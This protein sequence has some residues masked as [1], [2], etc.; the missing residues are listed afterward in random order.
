M[1][2]DI[3]MWGRKGLRRMN[4]VSVIIPNYNYGRF[5]REAIDSALNQT[6]RPHE[7]IVVDDGSTDQSGEILESYGAQIITVRQQNQGVGAARNK[8]AEI[9][10]GEYLAFLDADDY[11][12]PRKL[13]KQLAKFAEDAEIG[14]VHCGYRNV[15]ANGIL[16]DASL[17]GSE[18]WVRAKLLMFEPAIAAPGGTTMLRRAVFWQV[19]GYDTNPDLHPSEDWDLSY[20]IACKWKYGFVAEPLL[21]Y[22]QHGKGGHTNIRRMERAMLIGFGKAFAADGEVKTIEVECYA[23]LNMVLAGS[24]F[25]AGQYVDFIRTA[26]KS[27]WN[28]PGN[29]AY[30][31]AFPFR[32]LRRR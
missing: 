27:I 29:I 5:L 15:D 11:W 4:R 25:R 24:Y 1:E 20:R 9:A 21:F 12:A 3:S 19:G 28:S 18:G 22:R 2:I 32:R 10:T 23:K 8:G 14:L 6:V 16:R 26:G 30:F 17:D 13:E 31:A 7:V